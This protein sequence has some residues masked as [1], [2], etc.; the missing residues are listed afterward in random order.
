[1]RSCNRRSD[2]DAHTKLID[3]RGTGQVVAVIGAAGGVG[4]SLVAGA[5]ALPSPTPASPPD[6][7]TSW[8]TWPGPGGCRRIAP[9]TIS[10][11]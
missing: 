7:S 3:R 5:I 10:C 8:A 1:M 11:R 2:A 9:S 4:T 6:C